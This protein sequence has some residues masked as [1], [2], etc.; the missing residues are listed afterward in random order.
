MVKELNTYRTAENRVVAQT[1]PVLSLERIADETVSGIVRG[2]YLIIPG[3]IA[4][5]L[6]RINRLF[7]SIGR[8]VVD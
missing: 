3:R 5:F 1:A 8:T 2:R 6:D 7:P 4:R